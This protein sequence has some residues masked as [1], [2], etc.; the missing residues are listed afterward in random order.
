MLS[1][2]PDLLCTYPWVQIIYKW[3]ELGSHGLYVWFPSSQYLQPLTLVS[4]TPDLLSSVRHTEKNEAD[5]S[6]DQ[7]APKEEADPAPC[8]PS[9]SRP[10]SSV[11]DLRNSSLLSCSRPEL[12]KPISKMKEAK[13]TSAVNT[14]T[15]TVVSRAGCLP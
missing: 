3:T 13:S 11:P 4:G 5:S 12:S 10:Y 6:L 15:S 2:P 9:S 14:I 7:E 8:K 1:S